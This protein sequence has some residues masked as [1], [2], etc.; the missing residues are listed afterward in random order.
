MDMAPPHA[1]ATAPTR[2]ASDAATTGV[3]ARPRRLLV[4]SDEMEV[5][6]SQR[7]I[8]YLLGGLDRSQWQPELLY[9][10]KGSFLVDELR[11]QGIVV[12]HLPKRG[13]FDPRFVWR[14]AQLLR[15]GRYDLVHAFSLTAEL[16][17]AVARLLVRD[18]PVQVSSVRNLY[19][20]DSRLFWGL[21]RFNVW[22]SA[23]VIS[24]AQLAADDTARQIGVAVDRFDVIPN[25]IVPTL[26]IS[27][28]ERA[29]VRRSLGL[30]QGR[31]LGLF[32]GR[33]VHQK[34]L[35]CLLRA[36]AQLPPE[37]RPW[38]AVAGQGP[39]LPELQQLRQAAGIGA[40]MRFLGERS[41]ARTLMKAADFLVLPSWHEG[42]SNVLM[43]AMS[44]G[45]PV[46]ASRVGGTP[47]IVE[48][49][50]SGLLFD[51]DDADALAA[52]LGR[53]TQDAA[54]RARLSEAAAA[55]MR[56]RY[57]ISRMV[58]GTVAVYDRCLRAAARPSHSRGPLLA[59]R[60]GE[61]A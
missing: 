37:Q 59:D 38:L 8:S 13:R 45:C 7:Q 39:L 44:A 34:N 35:P 12:H 55:R 48:D 28:A 6:G 1:T 54:L 41:D 26:P 16:W 42:L 57:S 49:G 29:E 46:V 17:T 10:R 60:V 51:S 21:K 30:P 58:D 19:P 4:V 23:A 43:E 56:S 47:E 50:A 22:R 14:Y 5:G 15:R 52:H 40:D 25:G 2:P 61:D 53:I 11:A 36:L 9:F 20:T 31:V 33:L 3:A 27:A 32:V 24:N 18:A